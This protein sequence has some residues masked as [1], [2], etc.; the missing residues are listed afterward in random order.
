M[1]CPK[2]RQAKLKVFPFG[3]DNHPWEWTLDLAAQKQTD[4]H[5][6]LQSRLKNLGFYDGA[7]TATSAAQ[8]H[9]HAALPPGT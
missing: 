1:R 6:G 9:G 5:T 3:A 2:A 4:E 8:P 7:S